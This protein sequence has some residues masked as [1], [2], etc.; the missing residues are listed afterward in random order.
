M[1]QRYIQ[2]RDTLGNE[3]STFVLFL[4]STSLPHEM[5]SFGRDITLQM[6]QGQLYPEALA[7]IFF[8]DSTS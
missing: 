8:A 1:T 4:P 5:Q 6:T 2:P 3:I 7:S